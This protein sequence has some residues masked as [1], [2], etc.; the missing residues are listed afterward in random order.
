MAVGAQGRP[1]NVL[2]K[3]LP[4]A[5]RNTKND[6]FD[7]FDSSTRAAVSGPL[8]YHMHPGIMIEF[9]LIRNSE[10]RMPLILE[11]KEILTFWV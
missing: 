11:L 5:L 1:R 2:E 9:S 10:T 8:P 4:G 6:N 3:S 7:S